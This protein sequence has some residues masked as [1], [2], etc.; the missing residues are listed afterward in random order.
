[1]KKII[2]LFILSL[3]FFQYANALEKNELEGLRV[4]DTKEIVSV[5]GKTNIKQF[6]WQKC[7]HCYNLEPSLE[8]WLAQN[9]DNVNFEK[10]PVAWSETHIKDGD[11]YLIAQILSK[12]GKIKD[13]NKFSNDLFKLVFVEKLPLNDSNVGVIFSQHGVESSQWKSIQKSFFLKAEE[14][15]V[16]IDTKKYGI[17]GVPAFVVDGK[18]YTDISEAQGVNNLYKTLDEIVKINKEKFENKE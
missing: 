18:Y 15:R 2:L 9:K 7:P 12:Q 3:S 8:E 14:N 16:K 10:I 1:M 6:F 17:V 5:D 4:L 13:L 11:Y